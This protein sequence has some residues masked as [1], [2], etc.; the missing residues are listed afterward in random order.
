VSSIFERLLSLLYHDDA[1][2]TIVG[3][4]HKAKGGTFLD[5]FGVNR[6]IVF[7]APVTPLV[8]DA[9]SHLRLHQTFLRQGYLR[10]SIEFGKKCKKWTFYILFETRYN[11]D[12]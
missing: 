1:P 10:L 8:R 6:V 12:A 9:R 3:T 5:E 7:P 11:F 4:S 2:I